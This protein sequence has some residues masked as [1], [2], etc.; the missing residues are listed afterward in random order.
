MNGESTSLE[1][2]SA[3]WREKQGFESEPCDA[4]CHH[5]LG[6]SSSPAGTAGETMAQ[7]G[8]RAGT[9]VARML[10]SAPRRG[11]AQG[12]HPPAST[13]EPIHRPLW[14]LL[15]DTCVFAQ[16]EGHGGNCVT[17][18]TNEKRS[19]SLQL[20]MRTSTFCRAHKLWRSPGLSV[21]SQMSDF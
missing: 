8:G 1:A 4:Q 5:L 3:A 12:C 16:E 19:P 18:V 10:P 7:G 11:A 6:I 20:R 14:S 2:G 9:S 15:H 13:S 21:R 17:R